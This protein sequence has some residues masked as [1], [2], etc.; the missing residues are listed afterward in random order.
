MHVEKSFALSSG[1]FLIKFL[2]NEKKTAGRG[3]G[4][5]VSRESC[6]GARWMVSVS[7]YDC[8]RG[9]FSQRAP[10]CRCNRFVSQS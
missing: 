10:R 1:S 9:V 8:A 2:Q 4:H 5:P 6:L 7:L 3:R